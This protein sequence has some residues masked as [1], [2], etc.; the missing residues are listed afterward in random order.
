MTV[1]YGWKNLDLDRY[2][3]IG[4]GTIKRA[5]DTKKRS[6]AFREM[7]SCFNCIPIIFSEFPEGADNDFIERI[8]RTLKLVLA[9]LGEPLLDGEPNEL[10]RE[11]VIRGIE[12]A[13]LS[14]KYKGR[15]PKDIDENLF[16]EQYR[17][18]KN[19]ETAPKFICKKL[20]ISHATFYRRVK[21]YEEKIGIRKKGN[22]AN[23]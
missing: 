12:A 16:V 9:K 15:K 7:I 2:F 13:K 14:G 19:G 5:H 22:D 18:W 23:G 10:H 21:E 6:V 11:A 17:A 8:E 1:V 4:T 3:Y 20:N